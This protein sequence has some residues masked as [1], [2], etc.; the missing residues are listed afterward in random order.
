M[1]ELRFSGPVVDVELEDDVV[2][3]ARG[4]C[5][6]EE[7]V[8]GG[9]RCHRHVVEVDLL[10]VLEGHAGPPLL[11]VEGARLPAEDALEAHAALGEEAVEERHGGAERGAL[12][13][14]LGR[15]PRAAPHGAARVEVESAPA[16]S[17]YGRLCLSA[18]TRAPGAQDEVADVEHARLHELCGS[19]EAKPPRGAEVAAHL[20]KGVP[21]RGREGLDGL[22]AAPGP[23]AARREARAQRAEDNLREERALLRGV[24][25]QLLGMLPV[26]GCL[27]EGAAVEAFVGR[28]RSLLAHASVGLVARHPGRLEDPREVA[29]LVRAARPHRKIAV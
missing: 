22:H 15:A 9:A 3:G 7:R 14:V 10:P 18:L 28:V 16:V 1:Q 19:L 6:R 25:R 13:A 24:A 29:H 11:R 23:S 17:Q 4:V 26:L 27:R 21:A 20:G 8:R 2:L 12:C 5:D